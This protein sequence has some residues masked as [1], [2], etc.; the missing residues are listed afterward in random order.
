[1]I[2]AVNRQKEEHE[3][4]QSSDKAD[5]FTLMSNMDKGYSPEL[6]KRSK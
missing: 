1:L 4:L 3:K 2:A 6:I 5:N